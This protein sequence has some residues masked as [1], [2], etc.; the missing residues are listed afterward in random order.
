MAYGLGPLAN[1]I[2]KGQ[3]WGMTIKEVF[4]GLIYGLLSRDIRLAL[5]SLAARSDE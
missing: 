4:D 5:A 3:P 2:W 1:S